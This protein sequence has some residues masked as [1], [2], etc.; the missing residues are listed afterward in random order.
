MGDWQ[1]EFRREQIETTRGGH[2]GGGGVADP[3]RTFV[4]GPVTATA[5]DPEGNEYVLTPDE[6]ADVMEHGRTYEGAKHRTIEL[7]RSR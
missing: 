3:Y 2:Y 5:T 4:P 7:L 6:I 1:I